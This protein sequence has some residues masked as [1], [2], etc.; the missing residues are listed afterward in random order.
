M[1]NMI[2]KVWLA[3]ALAYDDITSGRP[4][5]ARIRLVRML[6]GGYWAHNVHLGWHPIGA[7]RYR[8]ESNTRS[9]NIVEVENNT[10]S[11]DTARVVLLIALLSGVVMA[12]VVLQWGL[13]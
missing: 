4:L 13:P 7:H 3:V 1:N 2:T 6:A 10:E 12:I 9:P 8:A 5:L 11:S